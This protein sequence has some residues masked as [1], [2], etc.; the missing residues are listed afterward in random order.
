MRPTYHAPAAIYSLGHGGNDAQKTIGLIW[1]LL[2]ASGYLAATETSPPG[3]S[4]PTPRFRAG[5]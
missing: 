1:M 4:A 5:W 3:M 2:V